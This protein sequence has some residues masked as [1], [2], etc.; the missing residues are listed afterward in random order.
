MHVKISSVGAGT[1]NVPFYGQLSQRG[2]NDAFNI[3]K[4]GKT[5]NA[6]VRKQRSSGTLKTLLKSNFNF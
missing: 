1:Q 5:H 2:S 4:G 3:C 6:S